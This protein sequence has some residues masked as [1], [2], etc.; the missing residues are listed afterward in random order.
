LLGLE[1]FSFTELWSPVFLVLMMAVGVLYTFVVGPW[2][3]RFKGNSPVSMKRQISFLLAVFLLYLTMG[4]PLSV[5]GHLMFTFHMVNMAISY[6]VVPTMLIYGIPDWLWRWAFSRTFW[7]P[8]RVLMNPLISLFLFNVL[9]SFYHMPSIHDWFMTNYKVNAVF[10]FVLLVSAM[11]N[12]W[13]IQCPVPEWALLTPLRRLGYIFANGL[14]LTPA[15][16]LIIF[17]NAPLFAVYNNPIIWAQAMQY[18]V[19][20]DPSA[21]LARFNGGPA[22]F[23]LL[24]AQEDQQLGAIAMKLLQ[25]LINIGALFIVFMRWYRHE[26]ARED[27]PSFSETTSAV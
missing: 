21:I 26:R 1:Y 11:M 10:Y 9:F 3:S 23:N 8:F 24:S 22:F 6:F 17:A 27:D 7:R 20:G 19:S 2:R 5:L 14:L 4:G 15:C 18:C 25:E 16:V 12:W 13:H